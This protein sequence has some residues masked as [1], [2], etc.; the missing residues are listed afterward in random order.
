MSKDKLKKEKPS[1]EKPTPKDGQT[2]RS[3][4][5]DKPVIGP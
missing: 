5:G 3:T 2:Q 4:P 1:K